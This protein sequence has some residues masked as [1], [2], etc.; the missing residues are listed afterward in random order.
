MTDIID[1]VK[2]PAKRRGRKPKGGKIIEKKEFEVSNLLSEKQSVIVHMK[3]FT[4]EILK[5]DTLVY[6]PN[7]E[8]VEP[9]TYEDYETC[10]NLIPVKEP[11]VKKSSSLDYDDKLK[12]LNII[13]DK[14][15]PK[16]I[17]SACFWCTCP[18]NNSP[19]FIPKNINDN[20]ISAYGCFCSPECALSFL[21]NEHI[22]ESVKIERI[23]LLNT[24]YCTICSYN[25]NIKPAISPFYTLDKYFGNLSIDEFRKLSNTNTALRYTLVEKPITLSNPEFCEDHF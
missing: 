20:S 1:P 7:I 10:C 9:F 3:C 13:L 24:V 16:T 22:D 12:T 2:T 6:T 21:L 8:Q 23:F 17:N 19:F 15:D 4:S 18:F 25:E 14:L 5:P 11:S